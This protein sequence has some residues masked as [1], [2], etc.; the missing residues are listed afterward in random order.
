MTQESEFARARQRMVQQQLEVRDIR[1]ARVLNA[2]RKVPRHQFVPRE[3]RQHAYADAPLPIGHSQTI[4]QPYI[5]ALMTQLLELEP[6][7]RVLEIGTGSGYQAAILAEL[8]EVVYTLERLA[9]LAE[10]AKDVLSHLGYE[11]V[12][13]LVGDG[14]LGLPEHAPYDGIIVTAAAPKAPAALQDQLGEGGRLVVPVGGREGQMLERWTRQGGRVGVERMVP[15][16]FVPLLGDQGWREA[17]P[18]PRRKWFGRG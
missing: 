13:V 14:S 12:V 6:S 8:S 17:S 11:N 1:D 3:S 9:P 4:S 18:R 7:D 10:R 16:A 5:V 15:V 2:M